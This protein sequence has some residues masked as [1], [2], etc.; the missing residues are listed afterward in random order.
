LINLKKRNLPS[1][2]QTVSST[3]SV[4]L[5]PYI[6][7]FP[8]VYIHTHRSAL[9]FLLEEFSPHFLAYLNLQSNL[10]NFTM[11]FTQTLLLA[12]TA[13]LAASLSVD[14]RMVGDAPEAR[15]ADDYS[16]PEE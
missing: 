11:L 12:A 15:S 14:M 16:N 9:P 7:K 2:Q 8:G 4:L 1:K 6:Y 3:F 10:S 5:Y 13:G